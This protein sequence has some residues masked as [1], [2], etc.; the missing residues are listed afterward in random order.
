M[1]FDPGTGAPNPYPSHA[2]QYR[3]YHGSKAWL[4]N[5]WTG[6]A[7]DPVEVGNDVFGMNLVGCDRICLLAK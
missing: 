3:K 7:R 4:F 5:P 6:A 1:H 2:G